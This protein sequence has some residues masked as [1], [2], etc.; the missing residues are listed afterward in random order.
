MFEVLNCTAPNW[1]AV[2]Q[3]M[4]SQTMAFIAKSSCEISAVLR[5]YT[6]LNGI[7]LLTFRD[8]PSVPTSRVKK[9]RRE[10]RA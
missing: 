2:H 10:K 8:N 4:R 3:A 1:F 6:A 9:S 7:S 5:Y